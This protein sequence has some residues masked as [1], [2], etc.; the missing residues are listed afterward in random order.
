MVGIDIERKETEGR[1]IGRI[2]L[3]EVAEVT[4]EEEVDLGAKT[5]GDRFQVTGEEVI[6]FY[7]ISKY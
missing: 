7:I 1:E 6:I 5:G 4:E 3:T 2:G